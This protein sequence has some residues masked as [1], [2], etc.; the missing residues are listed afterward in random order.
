LWVQRDSCA[1]AASYVRRGEMPE[2]AALK[3]V[4]N[5]LRSAHNHFE[6][7]PWSKAV[8]RY[9]D[10]RQAVGLFSADQNQTGELRRWS[11]FPDNAKA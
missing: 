7:W 6:H 2:D 10:L 4:E 9:E 11:C 1:V 5:R 3:N 8:I